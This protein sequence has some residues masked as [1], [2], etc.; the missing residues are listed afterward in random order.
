MH[1]HCTDGETHTYALLEKP[2]PQQSTP[3]LYEVPKK[4][5]PK[6]RKHVNGGLEQQGISNALFHQYDDPIKDRLNKSPPPKGNADPLEHTY[7]LPVTQ[8]MTSTVNQYDEPLIESTCTP[9][10]TEGRVDPSIHK[11]A[12]LEKTTT[13][14]K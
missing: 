4:I 13:M 10:S 1:V 5:I 14:N 6:L 3:Q 12:V 9:R 7:A 8:K 11:Y 2:Q